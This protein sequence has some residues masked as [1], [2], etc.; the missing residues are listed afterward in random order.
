[1]RVQEGRRSFCGQR[2]KEL[3]SP[4]P[5]VDLEEIPQ[6][7]RCPECARLWWEEIR[8]EREWERRGVLRR[9][10]A[11]EGL[12]AAFDQ[13]DAINRTI[14]NAADWPSAHAALTAEPFGYTD[15]QAFHILSFPA[16]RRTAEARADLEAEQL[17]LRSRLA[18]LD[19]FLAQGP[20]LGQTTTE[21]SQG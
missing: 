8:P 18:E 11:S 6:D 5:A 14:A 4:E 15:F 12:L 3:D 17:D 10:E 7:R 20:N 13:L 1:L 19:A 2:A 9:I 16:G 21:P